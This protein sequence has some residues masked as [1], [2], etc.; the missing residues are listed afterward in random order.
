MREGRS[1][2]QSIIAMRP[3]VSNSF[4]FA[5]ALI[6]G[7]LAAPAPSWA[8]GSG[9]PL[10][11]D[12][13]THPDDG[14]GPTNPGRE[15]VG[16]KLLLRPNPDASMRDFNITHIYANADVCVSVSPGS[17]SSADNKI[18]AGLL[19]WAQSDQ[20]NFAFDISPDGYWALISHSP[21]NP[22]MAL[23]RGQSSAIRTGPEAV[24][25]LEVR[26][27]GGHIQAFING[28]H[29]ADVNAQAPLGGG[30]AGVYA[31][32]EKIAS[33]PWT[34]SNFQIRQLQ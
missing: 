24:N 32:S 17:Y 5:G 16:G 25:E 6:L 27:N 9:A 31:A 3:I 19:F 34:F 18:A 10:F 1:F 12:D 7:I 33:T 2:Q 26:L 4:L 11:V 15:L 14:W 28:M 20:T 29:V 22:Q 8:C 30:P 21:D 13:F 23:A